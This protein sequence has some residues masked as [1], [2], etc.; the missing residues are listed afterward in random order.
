[1]TMPEVVA[2]V[3][4]YADRIDAPVETGTTVTR[5]SRSGDGYIVATD[6]ETWAC[7]TL[8]IASGA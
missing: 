6:R 1:M 5:V 8:V 3:Q 2:Y 4:A 7:R